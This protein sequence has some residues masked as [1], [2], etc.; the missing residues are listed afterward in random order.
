MTP[1]TTDVEVVVDHGTEEYGEHELHVRNVDAESA[2]YNS[3]YESEF[4]LLVDGE[5]VATASELEDRGYSNP[6]APAL[7]RYGRA[8]VD[9]M[10][11]R[12]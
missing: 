6:W 2:G 7:F 10:N 9:G 3:R 12:E 4:E 1:D 8:Y 5:V 11:H